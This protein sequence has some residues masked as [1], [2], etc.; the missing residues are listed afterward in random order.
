ME[1][2]ICS[3]G[4]AVGANVPHGDGATHRSGAFNIHG[5]CKHSR[6]IFSAMRSSQY[7]F[8]L[9]LQVPKHKTYKF[10]DHTIESMPETIEHR[11]IRS[12]SLNEDVVRTEDSSEL[13][14]ETIS[15]AGKEKTAYL[16]P[17]HFHIP[18]P[19]QTR[20]YQPTKMPDFLFGIAPKVQCSRRRL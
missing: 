14:V 12:K 11:I 3:A 16:L 2:N 9:C 19:P 10:A 7:M 15:A 18:Q 13:S 20:P 5:I 6:V 8:G 17:E 1:S 4:S